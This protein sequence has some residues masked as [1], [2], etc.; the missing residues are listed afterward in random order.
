MLRL[1]IFV[2]VLAT[3]VVFV[4][5]LLMRMRSGAQRSGRGPRIIEM[6]VP[7]PPTIKHYFFANF[8]HRVGPP[9]PNH[10][11]ETLVVHVGPEESERYRVYSMWVAT[12][13]A[14]PMAPEG[15]RFGRGLLIVER[16]NLELILQAVRQHITE[17]G[18][19]AE[20]VY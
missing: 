3:L 19:L 20:E 5:L 1:I 7:G 11:L 6:P 2:V 9:D 14:V 13:N 8:D 12:A 15:Y 16:Y 10:F 17:L 4:R 18:L